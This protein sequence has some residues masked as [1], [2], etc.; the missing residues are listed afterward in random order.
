MTVTFSS[1]NFESAKQ[2]EK[3]LRLR[4]SVS[5]ACKK[6]LVWV[7]DRVAPGNEAWPESAQYYVWLWGKSGSG[8]FL[9]GLNI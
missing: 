7:W 4:L 8:D 6:G 5:G 3:K 9:S 1:V 2:L